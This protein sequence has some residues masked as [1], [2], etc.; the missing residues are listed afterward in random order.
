MCFFLIFS[1]LKY[2][3]GKNT[4]YKRHTFCKIQ[5]KKGM[6]YRSLQAGGAKKA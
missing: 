2:H 5:K 1:R 6:R 3:V 4:F